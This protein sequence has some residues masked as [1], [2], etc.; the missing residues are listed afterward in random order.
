MK[1]Q[2]L[3]T[4]VI[5]LV[6]QRALGHFSKVAN[7]CLP[8]LLPPTSLHLL[9]KASTRRATPASVLASTL[10]ELSGGRFDPSSSRVRLGDNSVRQAVR[11]AVTRVVV[12][13]SV[14]VVDMLE[15][16]APLRNRGSLSAY[17]HVKAAAARQC[18]RVADRKQPYRCMPVPP[19]QYLAC[20]SRA[21]SPALSPCRP[22]CCRDAISAAAAAAAAM[23]GG[24]ADKNGSPDDY[25]EVVVICGTVF[26]M[27]DVREELGFDEPRVSEAWLAVLNPRVCRMTWVMAW[28]TSP[29]RA[30]IFPLLCPPWCGTSLCV[31]S[32][33]VQITIDTPCR[34]FGSV[35]G[36]R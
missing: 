3:L 17:M 14:V 32:Q 11:W 6:L 5:H 12:V 8:L 1:C 22:F 28:F 35:V 29:S 31:F 18:G 33:W 20:S 25:R 15:A 36:S 26:M 21:D 24:D 9:S 2:A 19:G 10:S 7:K 13:V 4:P 34:E 27:V 30:P 23:P 16:V